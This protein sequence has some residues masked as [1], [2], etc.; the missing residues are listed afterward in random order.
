MLR[1]IILIGLSM[2]VINCF[3]IMFIALLDD[4]ADG[5][6]SDFI[7]NKIKKLLAEWSE[8]E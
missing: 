8:E 4:I 6:I 7:G 5:A 2:T 1:Y 3:I